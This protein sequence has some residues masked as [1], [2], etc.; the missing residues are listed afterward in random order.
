[1]G[2]AGSDGNPIAIDR[3]ALEPRDLEDGMPERREA[4]EYEEREHR[5]RCEPKSTMVSKT[6]GMNAGAEFSGRPPT[7]SG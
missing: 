2:V 1:M 5:G 3:R 4:R 7:F 6:M